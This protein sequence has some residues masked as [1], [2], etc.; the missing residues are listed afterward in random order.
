M[1]TRLQRLSDLFDHL[2]PTNRWHLRWVMHETNVAVLSV[3]QPDR[4]RVLANVSFGPKLNHDYSVAPTGFSVSVNY[5]AF[6]GTVDQLE[7]SASVIALLGP[8]LRRMGETALVSGS[9]KPAGVD[10]YLPGRLSGG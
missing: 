6:S 7:E 4:E 9:T 2:W 5:P 1:T 10:A 8:V 3:M